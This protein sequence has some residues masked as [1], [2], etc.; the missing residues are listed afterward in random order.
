MAIRLIALDVDGTLVDPPDNM[1]I[2]PRILSAVAEAVRR[3]ITVCVA[4]GRNY[5]YACDYLRQS[6]A[7]GPLISCNG[8]SVLSDGKV[9]FRK[10][11]EPEMVAFSVKFCDEYDMTPMV[12]TDHE[13]FFHTFGSAEKDQWFIDAYT[14]D[15]TGAHA[16]KPLERGDYLALR[17]RA[18]DIVKMSIISYKSEEHMRRAHS[19]W[20]ALRAEG[21]I[22]GDPESAVAY[23]TCFEVVANGISKGT[24]LTA[25]A[26]SLGLD[27]SE[28]MA[29]GDQEND[30]PMIRAAGLGVAM[31][32]GAER[33]KAEAD[34]VTLSVKEG[35]AGAAIEKFALCD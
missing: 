10:S 1:Q 23:W 33:L 20:E 19:A 5:V 34:Y 26:K 9:Y 12:F 17:D 3:G 18:Q 21:K 25:L 24:G 2:H 14:C 22:P 8:A 7:N 29:I 6:G 11:L 32:N 27:M 4:S 13:V 31:G 16:F 15:G 35:G 30:L 28:V